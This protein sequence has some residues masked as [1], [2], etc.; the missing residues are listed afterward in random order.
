MR[1]FDPARDIAEH[2]GKLQNCRR[3]GEIKRTES[4]EEA[5]T[6]WATIQG[7]SPEA[8]KEHLRWLA[9]NDLFFLLV[10][11]LNHDH[12]LKPKQHPDQPWSEEDIERWRAWW[13]EGCRMV[14]DDENEN[15]DLWSRTSG[16]SSI[17]TFANTIRT[18]LRDPEVT[19]G[20][21]SHTRPIAKQFL[22]Q[23][24]IE[25]E[26]N[27]LLKWLFPD[28]LWESPSRE[29]PKWSQDDGLVVKRKSNP[30]ESTVEAWGLVDGQPT[31]KHWQ[32]L[33]YDDVITESA[34]TSPEMIDKTTNA[35][36]LSFNLGATKPAVKRACGTYYDHA[37]TYV[38]MVER[39]VFKKRRRCIVN[40]PGNGEP[41]MWPDWAMAKEKQ[42]YTSRN[43]ALQILLDT[44]AADKERGFKR[45]WLEY[46]DKPPEPSTLNIYILVDPASADPGA[47][48]YTSMWAIGLGPDECAY[49]LDMCRDRLTLVERG[50]ELFRMYRQF[51]HVLKVIYEKYG[52][53]AD[54]EYLEDR[55][56]RENF[57]FKN[58][59]IP[60]GG[61]TLSKEQRIDKLEPWFEDHRFIFPRKLA[62]K[63]KEGEIDLVK[64]FVE[65]EYCAYPYC[66]YKD[67]LDGLARIRDPEV[68]PVFPR[69]YGIKS[70]QF[71]QSIT[72]ADLGL[73]EGG[74][75]MAD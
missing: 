66:R 32:I 22:R 46:Y 60:V 8:R 16:K 29:S 25:F 55:Q 50:D 62:R 9:R 20:I 10:F 31:S 44:E 75:W 21:F 70:G 6:L 41:L 40:H 61:K 1:Q 65:R 63:T 5:E 67:M 56:K 26:G 38:I 47:V 12:I 13:F 71:G 68:N 23:I 51:P 33:I 73:D 2:L 34:V 58:K 3:H 14:Q 17:Q 35:M 48:S 59:I 45:E 42:Q 28:I 69:A 37:D 7:C 43:W 18:I 64:L 72:G 11:I 57:R 27:D 4:P 49:V 30:K 15:L 39:G 52:L 53:Q 19:I 54:I 74:S 36:E 24:K